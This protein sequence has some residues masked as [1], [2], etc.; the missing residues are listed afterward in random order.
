MRT[1][2]VT[3]RKFQDDH[4]RA[5]RFPDQVQAGKR[6]K[7]SDFPKEARHEVEYCDK[8]DAW[9]ITRPEGILPSVKNATT[10]V[11]SV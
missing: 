11:R 1:F 6:M 9:H 3:G 5:I 7:K 4:D 2:W 10:T 8:C